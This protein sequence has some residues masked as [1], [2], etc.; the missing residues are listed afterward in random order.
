MPNKNERRNVLQGSAP[1]QSRKSF[2]QPAIFTR[3]LNHVNMYRFGFE[4]HGNPSKRN[5]LYDHSEVKQ[6]YGTRCKFSISRAPCFF[7][8]YLSTRRNVAANPPSEFP[9]ERSNRERHVWVHLQLVST[10]KICLR[11]RL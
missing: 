8:F 6:Y 4:F 11:V 1:R 7:S 3:R 5:I 10:L 2:L 9:E